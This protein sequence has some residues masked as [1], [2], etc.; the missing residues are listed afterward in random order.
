MG[1]R[2]R[3]L[4]FSL[5]VACSHDIYIK[6]TFVHYTLLSHVKSMHL[7]HLACSAFIPSVDSRTSTER[8]GR[9]G[10]REEGRETNREKQ[11]RREQNRQSKRRWEEQKLVQEHTVV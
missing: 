8:D 11:S 10:Q 7:H 6:N 3:L 4:V 5:A 1:V 2:G 9:E